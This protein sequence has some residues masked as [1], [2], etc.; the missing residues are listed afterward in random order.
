MKMARMIKENDQW[1]LRDDWSIDDVRNVIECN[2]IEDAE[3][4]TDEDCVRV[5][6]I[7]ADLFDANIGINWDVIDGAI[8][9][10]I[11]EK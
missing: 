10:V 1:I 2:E 7:A 6:Q 11:G 5:L 3:N 4:F 8:M 9:L